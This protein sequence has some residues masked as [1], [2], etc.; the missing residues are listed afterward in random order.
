ML[1]PAAK[2]EAMSIRPSRWISKRKALSVVLIITVAFAISAWFLLGQQRRA[3]AKRTHCVGNLNH[4]RL[5]KSAC[6]EDLGIADGD[7]LPEKALE[8]AF[9]SDLGKPLAQY[10]CPSG[11]AY[12]IGRAGITPKCS[13]TNVCYTYRLDLAKLRVERRAWTHSLEQ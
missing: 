10:K 2:A 7:P 13:Y 1:S 6:Q 5:A 12:V 11:G 9:E 3:Y 4:I 8:Q